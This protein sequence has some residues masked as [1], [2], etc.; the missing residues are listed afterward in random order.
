MAR[1]CAVRFRMIES[2]ECVLKQKTSKYICYR[3]RD[4]MENKGHEGRNEIYEITSKENKRTYS[5][6]NKSNAKRDDVNQ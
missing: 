4:R 1:Y 2:F 6:Y 3:N 5:T